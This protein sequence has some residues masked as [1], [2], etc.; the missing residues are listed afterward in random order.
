MERLTASAALAAYAEPLLDGRRVVV[1][2][3]ATGSLAKL[4]VDRGARVV[5]VYDADPER[6]SQAAATNTSRN[7]SVAP[8]GEADVA[9]RDGAF[10]V[11]IVEWL[12]E[13]GATDL[14]KRVRR[15]LSPRGV[16]L[17]ASPNAEV[18]QTL[19]APPP[20]QRNAL[21]YYELYDAVSE[22]FD[23][24]RMLGQ[25][26]FV[27]YAVVDFAP[28]DEPDITVDTGF[29]AETREEPEWFVALAAQRPTELDAFS[30]VQLPTRSVLGGRAPAA[31]SHEEHQLRDALREARARLEESE[32]DQQA[33]RA[34][35]QRAKPDRIAAEERLQKLEVE[36]ARLRKR[37]EGAADASR[38]AAELEQVR[39]QLASLEAKAGNAQAQA[40]A[41]EQR[42]KD[43]TAELERREAECVTL[44][45]QLTES[46]QAAAHRTRQLV[47]AET[48][49][50]HFKAELERKSQQLEKVAATPETD[51]TDDLAKLEAA[52]AERGRRVRELESELQQARDV[53]KE[54][55]NELHASQAA[56]DEGTVVR[57]ARLEGDLQA[58]RWT[59]EELEGRLLRQD[60]VVG[61]RESLND[62]LRKARAELQRQAA[63]LEQIRAKSGEERHA[64]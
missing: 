9:V 36:N 31:R 64:R 58:A 37:Q 46:Q 25:T 23:E 34:E 2:G 28:E 43:A 6:A 30:V 21:G 15:A 49:V 62:A 48:S 56:S 29:V 35:L 12:G 7:V 42:L 45:R 3:D 53:G 61:E 19:L 39:R 57:A 50:N 51:A 59:I 55:I 18:R 54:L 4:L 14:L 26:P 27:G 16:A 13:D 44:K 32:R 60:R 52:L 17:I 33:L 20:T 11:A 41:A 1:F 10:D 22:Q 47:E 24:V 38:L 63:L 8:L 40:D 5:H